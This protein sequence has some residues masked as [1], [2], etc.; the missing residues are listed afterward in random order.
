MLTSNIDVIYHCG[1]V[2]NHVMSYFSLRDANVLGTIEVLRLASETKQ[3]K[4][5]LTTPD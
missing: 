4:V 2:V 5:E 3:K 1:A